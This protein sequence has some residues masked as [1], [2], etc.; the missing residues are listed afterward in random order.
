VIAAFE[1]S[2]LPLLSFASCRLRAVRKWVR[3]EVAR[4]FR[5]VPG[6][7]PDGPSARPLLKGCHICQG[8]APFFLSAGV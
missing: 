5:I 6:E 1:S 8:V 4:A 7:G 3:G 2:G